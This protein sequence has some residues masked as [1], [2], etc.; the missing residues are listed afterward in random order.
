MHCMS[1]LFPF[2]GRDVRLVTSMRNGVNAWAAKLHV[3]RVD[4]SVKYSAY[5][6]LRHRVEKM[7]YV[8]PRSPQATGKERERGRE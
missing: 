2:R 5:H 4:L 6:A 1:T 7:L 3:G 8:Y